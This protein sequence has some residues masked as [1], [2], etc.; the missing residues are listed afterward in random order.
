MTL[1]ILLAVP[2]RDLLASLGRFLELSSHEVTAVFDGI[3]AVRKIEDGAPDFVVTDGSMPRVETGYLV[4][5]LNEAGIPAVVLSG[6]QIGERMLMQPALPNSY[7][8]YPFLPQELLDR[9]GAVTRRV[10]TGECFEVGGIPVDGAGYRLGGTV[11]VTEEELCVLSRVAA[12]GEPGVPRPELYVRV[13]NAKLEKL[14]AAAH[15]GY[16]TRE[17]YRLVT[18]NE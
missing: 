13:L 15:I 11:R 1:R 16:I 2:D 12:G 10:R 14:R 6:R 5:L 9:I 3:Q 17:G 8:C 18:E 7:L 4:R